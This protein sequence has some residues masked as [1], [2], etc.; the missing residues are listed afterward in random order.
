[1]TFLL[2]STSRRQNFCQDTIG[3]RSFDYGEKKQGATVG[4]ESSNPSYRRSD[5]R[6]KH[7]CASRLKVKAD[8]YSFPLAFM[9][10]SYKGISI[11]T[12]LLPFFSYTNPT[13]D[14]TAYVARGIDLLL[15]LQP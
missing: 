4:G 13:N 9:F 15:K 10:H 3:D 7:S 2:V 11:V 12:R 8:V 1:M 14:T 6:L 5:R